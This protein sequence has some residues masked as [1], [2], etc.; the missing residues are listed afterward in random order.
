VRTHGTL[1]KWN[2]DRGFG[3]ITPASGS[4][5]VFVHISAFPRDRVPPRIGELV[6]FEVQTG[7]DGRTKAVSVMRPGGTRSARDRN[8]EKESAGP[9][10]LRAIVAVAFLAAVWFAV[11]EDHSPRSDSY[12]APDQ[13]ALTLSSPAGSSKYTC[14]GRQRCSEMKSCAEANYF[15]RHCPGTEMD[16]DNDGVPCEDQWCQ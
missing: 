2:S 9:A 4:A 1:S 10:I 11:N 5:D 13:T 8:A 7:A 15:I 6:S 12:V 16:G 3:F 14:D